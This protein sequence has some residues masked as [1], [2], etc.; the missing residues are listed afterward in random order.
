VITIKG[1]YEHEGEERWKRHLPSAKTLVIGLLI[2][3]SVGALIFFGWMVRGVS[4]GSACLLVDPVTGSI[5]EP[6][7]GPTWFVKSPWVGDVHYYAVDKVE[8]WT[9]WGPTVVG[10]ETVW[11]EIER[12]E[13]PAVRCLSSDGLEIEVDLLVRWSLDVTKLKEL[14]RN[15][16]DLQWKNKVITSVIR[17]ETRDVI[18]HYSAVEVIERRAEI[19]TEISIRLTEALL[20]EPSLVEAIV[21]GSVEV[22]F[23]GIDPPVEFLNAI[24][25]KLAAEQAM[26]QAEF[27]RSRM[28][29]LANASAQAKILEAYGIAESNLIVANATAEAIESIARETGMDSAEVGRIYLSMILLKEIAEKVPDAKFIIL[30]GSPAEGPMYLIPIEGSD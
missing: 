23:R 10:N 14:Y 9:N 25:R 4:V 3:L 5:S 26:I 16:P 17:E 12:G 20:A 2:L 18:S 30:I 28:L 6:I 19:T 15:F 11:V 27:E 7:I 13:F 21:R 24:Q 22:D 1:S 29:I 8:M